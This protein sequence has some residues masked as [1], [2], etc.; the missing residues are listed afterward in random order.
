VVE[1]FAA[2]EPRRGVLAAHPVKTPRWGC[3]ACSA[4][5]PVLSHGANRDAPL[6]LLPPTQLPAPSPVR[7]T[8]D[9]SGFVRL[10]AAA[11]DANLD[12]VVNGQDFTAWA[13]HYGQAGGWLEGDFNA[14]GFV[15]GGDFTLWADNYGSTGLAAGGAGMAAA[16]VP[17]PG[18]LAALAVGAAAILLRRSKE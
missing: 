7:Q 5:F 4:D 9:R 3:A 17:E 1:A 12:G 15:D 14:D 8:G 10:D 2:L 16:S 13:D 6:G 11:G 18:V